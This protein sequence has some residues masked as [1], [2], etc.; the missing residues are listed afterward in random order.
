MAS[1]ANIKR[2]MNDETFKDVLAEVIERQVHVF[3]NPESS[4][5]ERDE[6]HDIVK[7]IGKVNDYLDSVIADEAIR[8]RRNN[9]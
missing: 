5:G 8:D 1:I 6:A 3:L 7:A 4:T 2:L 9:K